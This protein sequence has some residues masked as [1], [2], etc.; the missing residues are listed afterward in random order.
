M[1]N[2][3]VLL[4][5]VLIII[6]IQTTVSGQ[7]YTTVCDNKVLTNEDDT[8]G[9]CYEVYTG[10]NYTWDDAN[11]QCTDNGG[12][13][14]KIFN[15]GISI[16]I[17]RI[18]Q[19]NSSSTSIRYWI[20][21]SREN[22]TSVFQWSDG[23][24]LDY[25]NWRDNHPLG[26]NNCV[27]V[28]DNSRDWVSSN[29]S[30]ELSYICEKDVCEGWRVRNGICYK[31]F[32]RV[33]TSAGSVGYCESQNAYSVE[34][35]NIYVF[36]AI[37]GIIGTHICQFGLRTNSSNYFWRIGDFPLGNDAPPIN[38]RNEY[39]VIGQGL[40]DRWGFES[41]NGGRRVI[42]MI[43]PLTLEA[44]IQMC[45]DT[46]ADTLVYDGICYTR[47]MKVTLSIDV[48]TLTCNNYNGTLY[49]FSNIAANIE[50]RNRF[51][52]GSDLV[53]QNPELYDRFVPQVGYFNLY[54]T[55]L[56]PNYPSDRDCRIIDSNGE[57]QVTASANCNGLVNYICLTGVG[58][59]PT[60]TTTTTTTTTIITTTPTPTKDPTITIIMNETVNC[61]VLSTNSSLCME[62]EELLSISTVSNSEVAFLLKREDILENLLTRLNVSPGVTLEV[63]A[64][65]IV[66]VIVR[67]EAES[68]TG[69]SVGNNTIQTN[70]KSFKA[71]D[72]TLI[73]LSEI[74]NEKNELANNSVSIVSDL[75]T[76]QA[77]SQLIGNLTIEYSFTDEAQKL[78]VFEKSRVQ[79]VFLTKDGTWSTEGITTLIK[80][81]GNGSVECITAHLTT[82]ALL[83]STAT[84]C[85]LQISEISNLLLQITSY[86]FLSISLIFLLTSLFI[87]IFS[88]KRFFRLDINV[89]HFNH[90]LSILL[91]IFLFIF[92]AEAF[93]E[94]P[95]VC[96]IVAFML[97]FLWINVFLSSLG[98]AILL[99]YSIW[100]VGLKTPRKLS[101]FLIPICW[102]VS[103]TWACVWIIYGK[104][105]GLGYLD[106]Q[107]E[108]DRTDN[109]CG[110][111]CFISTRAN[112]I[113]TFLVPIFV[114]LF[115]N[116]I[117]L[118]LVLIKIRIGLKRKYEM[119]SELIRLR[120]LALGAIV[121]VPTLSLPFI[122]SLP[123]AFSRFYPDNVHVSTIFLW[124]YVFST[125]PIGIIHFFLVTFR[126]P[127]ARIPRVFTR[128][129]SS[130]AKSPV[131]TSVGDSKSTLQKSNEPCKPLKLNLIRPASKDDSILAYKNNHN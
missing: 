70:L 12:R 49:K 6:I 40:E 56:D 81:D 86:T 46:P 79:C 74:Y 98:I 23:T 47:I 93:A 65:S 72:T 118:I 21:L 66:L 62:L 80:R 73:I 30:A 121:L 114:V 124:V 32:N 10:Q 77:N 44:P 92:G 78:L 101:P 58:V 35:P 100:I 95:A 110:D 37:T 99:I 42:C 97:H 51:G 102:S 115:V 87:F 94:H 54:T 111:S 122:M 20:G 68:N 57:M 119:E 29:C 4:N 75:I 127:Q 43:G 9:M 45:N 129:K 31:L 19:G 117:I 84:Q 3:F 24:S 13:L 39:G 27:S 28:R 123:L 112:L 61:Y 128:T 71:T 90:T 8:G 59:F 76:I 125:T 55:R 116:I 85:E 64:E 107:I 126:I 88:G 106:S 113:W 48:A 5:L 63:L 130:Q 91:A 131:T 15:E 89:L 7:G 25:E 14:A 16:E 1:V 53:I 26:G 69:V 41:G 22:S 11:T 108:Y 2:V 109:E 105:V 83:V 104:F 60:K 33:A 34:L 120:K 38:V 50:L 96:T 67:L 82:F 36:N 103:F 52:S 17:D 18:I